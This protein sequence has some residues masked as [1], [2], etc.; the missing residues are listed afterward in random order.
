MLWWDIIGVVLCLIAVLSVT[1]IEAKHRRLPIL[2]SHFPPK[3]SRS[4]KR[5]LFVLHQRISQSTNVGLSFFSKD[6]RLQVAAAGRWAAFAS[7]TVEGDIEG[8][9]AEEVAEVKIWR[10]IYLF[11]V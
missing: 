1:M 3:P 6:L 2:P 11:F 7:T 4:S 10:L 5:H 9:S 8:K